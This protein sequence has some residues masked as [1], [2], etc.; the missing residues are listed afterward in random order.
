MRVDEYLTCDA[1]QLADLLRAGDVTSEMLMRH[2]MALADACEP[3]NAIAYRDDE[4]AL[5]EAKHASREGVF[6]GIPFLLKDSS[7][8][9]RQMP[10]G[11]GSRLFNDIRLDY[12]ATLATRFRRLGLIPFGRTSV[13][14]LCM[15]PTTE[16]VH[17]GGP[18]LNPW[19]HSRSSGGSSGGAAVAVSLGIVP[20]AHGSDGG[21]SIRI[22]AACCGVYGL[23]PSRGLIPA[24]PRRGEIWGGLATDGVLSRTVRDTAAALDGIAGAEVGA[25]Y[26]APAFSGSYLEAVRNAASAPRMTV[27]AWTCAW[28]GIEVDSSCLHAVHGVMDLCRALGHTVIEA[29][30]PEL[31]YEAFVQAHIDILATHIVVA[32]DARRHALGAKPI[33]GD[34]EPAIDDGYAYGLTLTAA[35]YAAAMQEI[36]A[37]GYAM[38][39]A[40]ARADLVLTPTLTQLPVRLG[41]MT[42]RNTFQAF[43]RK[44]AR[45]ATFLA[46]VNASGQPAANVPVCWSENNLPVGTQLI[47]PVGGEGR[48]LQLSAELEQAAPWH[49]RRPFPQGSGAFACR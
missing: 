43:R 31:D 6:A 37:V 28:P 30:L 9:W 10:Y 16:A 45:Y 3:L 27:H 34:L 29:P 33:V 49:E 12:D 4:M 2:A 19:D 48:I 7:L 1:L 15:A 17:N 5:Q 11:L 41:E 8:A 21:G 24:G 23:K 26:A 44:V 14:E 42:M 32:V 36:H 20:M 47:G 18:T 39:A 13:P 22:P 46:V 35:R 40:T 38:Q 25:P